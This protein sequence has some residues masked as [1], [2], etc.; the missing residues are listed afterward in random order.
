[1]GG[2]VGGFVKKTLKMAG[3]TGLAVASGGASELAKKEVDKYIDS[4]TPPDPNLAGMADEPQFD[5][6]QIE[7][8]ETELGEMGIKRRRGRA[9]TILTGSLGLEGGSG[10][11]RRTLLGA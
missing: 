2:S 10:V 11:A 4:L 8:E 1:M 9:S 7:D 3:R 5:E 6:E